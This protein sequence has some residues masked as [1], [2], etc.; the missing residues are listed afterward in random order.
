MTFQRRTFTLGLALTAFSVPGWST[1]SA[2]SDAI[3]KSGRQRMLSQRCAKAYLAL[4]LGVPAAKPRAVLTQSVQ[5]FDQSLAE[6]RTTAATPAF[7]QAVQQMA[8]AWVPYRAALTSAAPSING[9]AK[10]VSLS[11]PV[12]AA[13][14]RATQLLEGTST[15]PIGRLVNISGRERMLSQ[16]MAM[17]YYASMAKIGAAQAQNEISLARNEYLKAF[18]TLRNAP[19]ATPRIKRELQMAATQWLFFNAAIDSMKDGPN[20]RHYQEVFSTSEN[21]L[22][23]LN[24]ATAMYAALG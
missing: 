23:V 2:L 14:Q 4:A 17:L 19:Q 15:S 20:P 16:R 21:I 7:A 8:A 18:D 12:L 24:N 9:G 1:A 22:T 5:L 13:A 11:A 3:N 6:L 10:V